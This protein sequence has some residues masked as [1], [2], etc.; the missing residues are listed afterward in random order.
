MQW[1]LIFNRMQGGPSLHCGTKDLFFSWA[2]ESLLR[3]SLAFV[4]S[5]ET[6]KKKNQETGNDSFSAIPLASMFPNKAVHSGHGKFS[7]LF[8]LV[9]L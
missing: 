5:C 8:S 7:Y 2:S 3:T 4:S 1:P 6:E 9:L